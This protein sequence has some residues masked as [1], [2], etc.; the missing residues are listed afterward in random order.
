MT[1]TAA[2]DIAVPENRLPHRRRSLRRL[3]TIRAP[4]GR[5]FIKGGADRWLEAQGS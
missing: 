3:R 1:T 5:K 4:L 2:A